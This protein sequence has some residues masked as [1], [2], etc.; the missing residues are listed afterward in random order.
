MKVVT[1]AA[2]LAAGYVLGTRAGREK[3]QQIVETARKVGGHPTVVQAQEKARDLIGAGADVAT[4]KL[5]SVKAGSETTPATTTP[6]TTMPATTMPATT[7]PRPPRR[8]PAID[9]VTTTAPSV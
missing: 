5:A 7:M 9:D 3:Y 2:G 4:A 8:K 1:F 6:A